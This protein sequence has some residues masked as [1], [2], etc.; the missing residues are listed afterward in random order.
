M[1]LGNKNLLMKVCHVV[2][3]PNACNCA[4]LE[5][6]NIQYIRADIAPTTPRSLCLLFLPSIYLYLQSH[7]SHCRKKQPYNHS[8]LSPSTVLFHYTDLPSADLFLS[9][10][11]SR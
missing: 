11:S 2:S 3:I 8:F 10:K 1:S 9:S 4:K 7:I 5:T 6:T